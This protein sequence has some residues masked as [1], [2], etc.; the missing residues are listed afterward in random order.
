MGHHDTYRQFYLPDLIER[1]FS[2]IYFGTPAQDELVRAVARMGLTWD[3]RAPTELTSQQKLEVR[4]HPHLVQLRQQR[5]RYRQR[6]AMLGFHPLHTAAG[7][8]DYARYKNL[9]RKINSATTTLK[10]RRLDEE[11]RLFHDTIDDL[12]IERQLDGRQVAEPYVSRG[13]EFESSERALVAK[14]IS[15][16]LDDSMDA[17]MLGGKAAF[18]GALVKLCHQQEGQRQPGEYG[19]HKI[20][21]ISDKRALTSQSLK[22]QPTRQ[23]VRAEIIDSGAGALQQL[24][25][26]VSRV[27]D[28]MPQV[29]QDR[30]CLLCGRDFKRKIHAGPTPRDSC[31]GRSLCRALPVSSGGLHDMVDG[32]VTLQE[33]L[34]NGSSRISLN[35]SR[36]CSY[37]AKEIQC[38]ISWLSHEVDFRDGSNGM[39]LGNSLHTM[40]GRPDTPCVPAR[41]GRLELCLV[42]PTLCWSHN[43]NMSILYVFWSIASTGSHRIP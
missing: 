24:K 14:F 23:Q 32:Q 5:D 11:I 22:M 25:Q 1:D 3:K 18:I 20:C 33:S 8:P 28:D 10:K 19:F 13:V 38:G 4:D 42:G 31:Q 16:S 12:E 40:E 30:V 43:M 21:A 39:R 6:L 2:S 9:D 27:L 35:D 15:L 36:F 41:H 34:R 26:S 29:F 7:H 17:E 37:R